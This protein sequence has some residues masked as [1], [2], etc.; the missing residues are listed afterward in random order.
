MQWVLLFLMGMLTV[1]Q[2]LYAQT[3]VWASY[4]TFGEKDGF[5]NYYSPGRITCD[6]DGL[7]WIGGDNGLYS[8][9]GTHFTNYHH[10]AGND[11]SLPSNVVTTNYQDKTGDYWVVVNYKGLYRFNPVTRSFHRFEYAGM[12]QFNIHQYRINQ[13]LEDGPLLWM[14]LP[15]FGLAC[16]NRQTAVM[17]PYK[18]CP[19][20]S[21]GG[22]KAASW[23]T[24]M[25]KDPDDGSF[26]L[27]SNDGL[28]QF[29]PDSG[30]CTMYGPP[31]V[32]SW[33][34]HR[35]SPVVNQLLI[36]EAGVLWCG[37]WG[38]GLLAFNRHNKIF[39]D[40][41]WY[42]AHSGTKNICSAIFTAGK[43]HLWIAARDE[44][45]LLF[46][47]RSGS[48]RKVKAPNKPT[49]VIEADNCFQTNSHTIWIADQKNLYR[50]N[51]DTGRVAWY[52][53]IDTPPQK[54]MLSGF[55]IYNFTIV[56]NK[57][58]VGAF[59]NA[60]FGWYERA[61][62]RFYRQRLSGG[63]NNGGVLYLSC[64]RK[65]VIWAGTLSGT[66]LYTG[67]TGKLLSPG[68]IDSSDL[69]F[70]SPCH[71]LLHALN[72]SHWL[73]TARGLM[74]Y[75]EARLRI[76][77]FD[78]LQPP[79]HRLRSLPVYSVYEDGKGRIWIGTPNKGISCYL[80]E[81]DSVVQIPLHFMPIQEVCRS[82]CEDKNG[83][84]LFSLSSLGLVVLEK[85]FTPR[86]RIT[87][88]NSSN[89][90]PTDYIT[91]IFKDHKDR[92]WL[93]TAKGLLLF[94]AATKSCI[95]F[96]QKDGLLDNFIDSYPY[97][98]S[99]GL[100]YI[101]FNNGFQT[102]Y[103][104]SLLNKPVEKLR[105]RLNNLTIDGK[106]WSQHPAYSNQITLQP[107][108]VNIA[109]SFA[110]VNASLSPHYTYAYMLNGFD[111]KWNYTGTVPAGQYNQIPPGRYTLLIKAAI[112]NKQWISEYFGMPFV[113]LP[114]WYQT[115]WCKVL[116]GLA[117]ISCIYG[118]FSYRL[119]QVRRETALKEDFHKKIAELEMRT[120]RAQMNP[121]FIFN[122]LSSINRYIVKSDHKTASGYLTKFSKLIRLILDN[123]AFDVIS[124]EKELQTLQ[125]YID[126][127][128]LRYDHAFT[129]TIRVDDAIDREET[130]IPSMLLQPYV[131]NAIW[132]GLL[133]KEDRNG[134]LSI[135]ISQPSATMLLARIEDNGVG[136]QQAQE[137]KSKNVV[138]KKSYGMQLTYERLQL[139][140]RLKQQ[141]PSV[142]VEDLV[143][144]GGV[145]RGTRVILH[146]PVQNISG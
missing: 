106:Q 21:C 101:G 77:V 71:H 109:F 37:T 13:F 27:G 36:D 64:D 54:K 98:D 115:V 1:T 89:Y 55:G 79:K 103:P 88:C 49:E 108:Q 97:Q 137:M 118:I 17:Q 12:N 107:K 35:I 110:V 65:G 122:S 114:A 8:F 93:N 67:A 66:W 33:D 72:G 24:I 125:L 18:I 74:Q 59:Y 78:T 61:T 119:K 34:G 116:L 76:K 6:K 11:S 84:I 104:D 15:D 45:L 81:L 141:T 58:F 142:V 131:E 52:P 111:K 128:A 75:D 22:Y 86:Q 73:A 82:F 20:G 134:Q 85:P 39:I 124:V 23:V 90:L 47:K 57:L 46:N 129:Y 43:G 120:L 5:Q 126:L 56:K 44:G 145:S 70:R 132:H 140:N 99:S 105:I 121:H 53:V 143:T 29:R 41:K 94:D 123:S 80:P 100:M 95:S 63:R 62:Q 16:W 14:V 87:Y 139:L 10:I 31:I 130:Y 19:P 117:V 32:R 68:K 69:Y 26:W 28:L 42:P 144:E 133:H 30:I 50:Y 60:G 136:R 83:N 51:L 48:F 112:D 3:N 127:E 135:H 7:L 138:K 91:S 25:I 4:E 9:D 38:S 102:F 40:Y 92:I 113:V 146:I 96:T 2:D